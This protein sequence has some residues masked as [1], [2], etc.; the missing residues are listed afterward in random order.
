VVKYLL[1]AFAFTTVMFAMEAR[2]WRRP[3]ARDLN[4]VAFFDDELIRLADPDGSTDS[5]RWGNLE[6]ISVE[7]YDDPQLWIGPYF[8]SMTFQ[9]GTLAFPAWTE[10]LNALMNRLL[11]F[12]G[13][14]QDGEA[15]ALSLRILHARI[16]RAS[17]SVAGLHFI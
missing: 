5:A 2:R 14:N 17:P 9:S 16:D 4:F 11:E 3:V 13:I 15:V 10:G 6:R 7:P 1:T 8:L 12:P